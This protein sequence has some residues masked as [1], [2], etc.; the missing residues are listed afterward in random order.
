MGPYL[1]GTQR[2]RS[3]QAG[4]PLDGTLPESLLHAD[5]ARPSRYWRMGPN[6][7]EGPLHPPRTRGS[8]IRVRSSVLLDGDYGAL[9]DH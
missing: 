9:L 6:R 3:A 1:D 4:T 8:A 5:I 7:K 2:F